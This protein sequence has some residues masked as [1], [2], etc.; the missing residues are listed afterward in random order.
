MARVLCTLE[1]ASGDI[2]GVKFSPT[3][4]G[5]L[6]EEISAELAAEW[7][8]IPGFELVDEV[9]PIVPSV[10]PALT[11]RGRKAPAP[12]PAP[13]PVQPVAGDDETF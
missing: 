2:S 12:T 8:T 3:D 4:V 10:K 5:M 7:A 6:S 13:A 11:P 9:G 1:N